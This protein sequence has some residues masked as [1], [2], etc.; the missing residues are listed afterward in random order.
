MTRPPILLLHGAFSRGA[1]LVH[2]ARFLRAEG[3]EVYTPSL[4]GHDPSD[5]EILRRLTLNDYL[6][7]L[8]DQHAALAEPPV[9]IGHSMGGL[10]AQMLA[11]KARCR[12]IVCVASAHPGPLRP[13][14]RS[15][16]YLIPMLPAL[17][18]ETPLHLPPSTFR[19]LALN[20]IPADQQEL[21]SNDFG[22]ESALAFRALLLG[23]AGF[24]PSAVTSPVLCL[25]GGR[26]R[27]IAPR[28]ARRTARLYQATH[29][30]FPNRGHWLLGPDSLDEVVGALLAW[31]EPILDHD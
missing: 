11:A 9:V 30:H 24:D 10:L 27:I 28:L 2:W 23:R 18:Q 16:P 8:L 29:Q 1:H 19:A 12:A 3:Y 4:P 25:S 7:F 22:D 5:P 21:L 26:D 6:Q 13:R 31:L 14:L 17:I 20:D 15:I